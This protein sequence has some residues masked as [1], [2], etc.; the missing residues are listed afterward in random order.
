MTRLT[1]AALGL[2]LTAGC[3]CAQLPDALFACEADRS[4]AQPGFICGSDFICRAPNDGGSTGTDASVR[5]DSGVPDAGQAIDS[6]AVT[7]SGTPLTD[8]GGATD[9]GMPSTDAGGAGL[10]GGGVV[11]DAG[12]PP[13][14]A[15]G[16]PTDAGGPPTDAGGGPGDAGGG[17]GDA[18]GPADA[19]GCVPSADE[20]DDVF[21]PG[22][23]T[24]CDGIDGDLSIAALVDSVTGDDL[25]G[26]GSRLKPY[27]TIAK[28]LST[29]K[30]QIL[31]SQGTYTESLLVTSGRLFGGYKQSAGWAR[32]GTRP[33]IVGAVEVQGT[34]TNV[35]L[36]FVTITA[37]DDDAGASVALTV[38]GV[39]AGTRIRRSVIQAGLGAPGKNAPQRLVADAGIDGNEG[40][41]SDDGG[42]GGAETPS[43][44]NGTQGLPGAA[45]G[46][47]GD[48]A[49]V[50]GDGQV[51]AP[52]VFGGDGGV[53]ITCTSL[54]CLGLAGGPGADGADGTIGANGAAQISGFFLGKAWLMGQANDGLTGGAGVG[55]AGAGGG[56]SVTAMNGMLLLLG[57]G[58]GSGGS[59]GCPGLGGIGGQGGGASVSM[60]VVGGSPTLEANSFQTGSAGAGG[61]GA[62]GQ[63]GGRGG[64]GGPGGI[65]Q[66]DGASS[67]GG[68]GGTGGTGGRG[69]RGGTGGGGAG[70]PS[71]GV[72][73]VFSAA[74]IF[75][76]TTNTY[77][78]GPAGVGG[79]PNGV[80]GV[81]SDT[82]N[83][84]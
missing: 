76:G 25:G 67:A 39:D 52:A 37:P 48:G 12:G 30:P 2:V 40:I 68:A 49:R 29:L 16:P 42:F 75:V 10:D 23:D 43:V 5:T 60:L 3:Q 11:G 41:S 24:N 72:W 8:A 65:G 51:G 1:L 61:D 47:G 74:P 66:P 33:N 32:T 14:D 6:G 46:A 9:S 84:P 70:G 82:R 62:P 36:D 50:G 22:V 45:G 77:L 59:A 4:C 54:P 18:G 15:G 17:Q 83:C 38:V 79:G 56:G 28:A 13:T 53:G 26:D 7:D 63:F 73:C 57:G 27:K 19:G 69:G 71:V 58:G 35:T 21:G 55:G 31:I 80:S 34:G 81:T 78:L 20:P 64:R 44:C